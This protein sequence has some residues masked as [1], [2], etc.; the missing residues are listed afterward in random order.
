[1]AGF[2]GLCACALILLVDLED[3]ARDIATLNGFGEIRRVF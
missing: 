1:M 2:A 3:L